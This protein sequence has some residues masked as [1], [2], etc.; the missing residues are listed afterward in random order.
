MGDLNAARAALNQAINHIKGSVSAQED[1]SINL[2]KDLTKALEGLKD[3][4]TYNNYGRNLMYQDMNMLRNERAAQYDFDEYATQELY[5]TPQ[6]I[7]T[8]D[9]WA[10]ED[11]RSMCSVGFNAYDSDSS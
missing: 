11:S 10:A 3:V 6:K 1:I 2:V 4:R 8:V 7:E 5:M 9:A